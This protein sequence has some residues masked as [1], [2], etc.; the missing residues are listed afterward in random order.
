MFIRVF[1]ALRRS[2]AHAAPLVGVRPHVRHICV[3]K[4]LERRGGLL[5]GR[6]QTS[7]G[8]PRPFISINVCTKSPLTNPVP[9]RWCS[10]PPPHPPPPPLVHE[11]ALPVDA[12]TSYI[13]ECCLKTVQKPTQNH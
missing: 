9:P 11:G 5:I 1:A 7:S 8:R 2:A 4:Y 6:G 13:L 12:K 10:P 3:Y